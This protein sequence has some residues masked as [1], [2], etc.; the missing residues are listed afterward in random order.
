MKRGDKVKI[1]IMAH[2]MHES[3]T[4]H[5]DVT[6]PAVFIIGGIGIAPAFSIIKDALK[7]KLSHR[8]ILFYSNRRPEDA[9]F[10]TE[11]QQLAKEHK[12]FTFVPTMTD[13]EDWQGTKGHINGAMLTEL[14]EGLSTP[15]YYV[16][17][18]PVM[19]GTV[20]ALLD[21]LGVSSRDIRAEEFTG[22]NLNELTKETDKHWKA[23]LPA[24]AI[25]LLIVSVLAVHTGAVSSLSHAG[26]LNNLSPNNPL[27]YLLVGLVLAVVVIKI[28]AIVKVK[29]T[30]H[31]NGT[32]LSV[33]HIL[34]AHKIT[35]KD[36]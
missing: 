18:L 2:S 26:I 11:L 10:L 5:D 34:E 3:F 17:G 15:I 16:A 22:F 30:L 21:K 19:V 14:V 6:R 12:N 29:R 7:R 28:V 27:S 20:N 1:Q 24:A 36:K 31:I 35:R 33:K 13:S 4:L 25:V 32:Q 9:P 23:Y 8:I